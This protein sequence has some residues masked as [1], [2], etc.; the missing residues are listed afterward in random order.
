VDH[1]PEQDQ[2][3]FSGDDLDEEEDEAAVIDN[4]NI[5]KTNS[6]NASVRSFGKREGS[7]ASLDLIAK[8]VKDTVARKRKGKAD[9]LTIMKKRSST[10]RTFIYVRIPAAKHCISF[11]GPTQSTFYNLYNFPF[12]QPKLE[13]RNKTWSVAE[14]IEEIQK[15]KLD[16]FVAKKK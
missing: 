14:M 16:L 1:E 10:N 8:K 4:L 11:Q 5:S 2:D 15:R 6:N 7:F 12:K 13:Y 3:V 9:E